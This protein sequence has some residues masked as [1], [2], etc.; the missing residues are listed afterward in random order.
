MQIQPALRNGYLSVF[1]PRR[2]LWWIH[3]I[4]YIIYTVAAALEL[5]QST[6]E[7]LV[8]VDFFECLLTRTL[9]LREIILACI[10]SLFGEGG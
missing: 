6:E 9:C 5:G 8:Y 10:M 7:N 2:C 4:I 1:D 3:I